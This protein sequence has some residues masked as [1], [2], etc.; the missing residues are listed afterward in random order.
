MGF[1]LNQLCEHIKVSIVVRAN[2]LRKWSKTRSPML[3]ADSE[4]TV[5]MRIAK[6]SRVI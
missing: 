4:A 1:D 6:T 5:V 3:K 2:E